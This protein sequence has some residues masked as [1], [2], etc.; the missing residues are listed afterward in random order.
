MTSDDVAREFPGLAR[1]WAAM[2]GLPLPRNA[3]AL[4]DRRRAGKL[5]DGAQFVVSFV[6]VTPLQLPHV[7]VT[8]GKQYDWRFAANMHATIA[9]KRGTDFRE[10][11]HGLVAMAQPYPNLIDFE[12]KTLA[13]IVEKA[14]GGFKLWPR[15]RGSAP[16]HAVFG[17][18]AA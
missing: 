17:E 18:S 5:E 1:I 14:G 13:S 15:A 16:W 7:F 2:D 8:P 12:S 9:A 11:L 4:V 3:Q 6:D 10:V